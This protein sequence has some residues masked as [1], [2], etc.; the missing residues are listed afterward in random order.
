MTDFV[1]LLE[2]QLVEA[3]ARRRR[4]RAHVPSRRTLG[5][6]VLAAAAAAALLVVIVGLASPEGGRRARPAATPAPSPRT[7]TVAIFNAARKPGVVRSQSG[8]L[9]AGGYAM[10]VF[11][12][13]PGSV[14]E[15]SVVYYA[16]GSRPAAVAIAARE[17]VARVAPLTPAIRRIALGADVAVV[18]GADHRP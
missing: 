12:N 13:L 11:A 3:H 14:R 8:R 10:S 18:I 7:T 6:L 9:I 1:D 15:R 17:H 5:A 2:A 4:L 16:P